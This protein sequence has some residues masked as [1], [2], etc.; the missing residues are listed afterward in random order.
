M[1]RLGHLIVLEGPDGVGKSMLGQLL[2]DQ[3]RD[4]GL[5]C[6]AYAFPGNEP[7]T[8][9]SLVYQLHHDAL[10]FG[11]HEVA[12]VAL[13]AAHIAAH[14]DA[15][16]R[17]FRPQLEAGTSIVLDRYWWS[18]EVYGA[19]AGASEEVLSHLLS[20]ERSCWSPLEPLLV[21]MINCGKP[22][23]VPE[24]GELWRRLA[25]EYRRLAAR[26]RS[27]GP[28][29]VVENSGDP[30]RIAEDMASMV[31]NMEARDCPA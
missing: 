3:L 26:E 29:L 19:L 4:A 8:L 16:E 2:V 7:G 5:E 14:L 23:R 13:Q 22:W 6:Q 15:I 10:A 9:G 30:R 17:V 18:T 31:M 12:P 20:A 1:G 25:A 21:F 27:R 24:D 11:V 28:V